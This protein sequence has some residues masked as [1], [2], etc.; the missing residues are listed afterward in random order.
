MGNY[1]DKIE[2]QSIIVVGGSTGYVLPFSRHSHSSEQQ[3]SIGYGAAAALLD[4]GAKVTV[5]SSNQ[6]KLNAALKQLKSPNVKGIVTDVRD[7]AA[8]TRTLQDL[9]PVDHVVFSAVDNIIRGKLVDANLDDAKHLFGVKF[10]GA[11]TVGKSM[12]VTAIAIIHDEEVIC[13]WTN[14][15]L[16]MFQSS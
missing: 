13:A 11:V 9:A 10:W 12:L 4:V 15:S 14:V 1:K 2:G 16:T 5:I 3:A 8:F 6:T 7:E